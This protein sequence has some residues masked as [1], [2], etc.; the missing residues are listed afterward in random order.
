VAS[1]LDILQLFPDLAAIGTTELQVLCDEWLQRPIARD[2]G[3]AQIIID[4]RRHMQVLVDRSGAALDGD[5]SFLPIDELLGFIVD[6]HF[7]ESNGRRQLHAAI[8]DA[9][10]RLGEL[11]REYV[12]SIGRVGSLY[13][14]C[15]NPACKTQMMTDRKA[16]AEQRINC[17][18]FD[19]ECLTCGQI[20]PY[21]GSDFKLRY[22]E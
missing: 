18:T 2:C 11:V 20:H 7:A 12:A 16:T 10:Q 19:I 17:P 4:E 22:D 3:I 9:R 1:S 13:L 8:R 14:I 5:Y 21:G 15:K 6:R